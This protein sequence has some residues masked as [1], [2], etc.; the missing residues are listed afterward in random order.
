HPPSMALENM[1]V[2]GALYR[3]SGPNRNTRFETEFY[4]LFREADKAMNTAREFRDRND[5][6]TT[7]SII[8]R[9]RNEVM[10]YEFMQDTYSQVR[11][12]NQEIT[13]AYRSKEMGPEEKR[14]YIEHLN[15]Q[16]NQLFEHAVKQLQELGYD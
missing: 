8:S 10:A 15:Q 3:G 7:R 1:P 13:K 16:K 12:M 14:R 2:V 5:P 6:R 9:H 11:D 4:D